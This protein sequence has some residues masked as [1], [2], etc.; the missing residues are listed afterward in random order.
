VSEAGRLFAVFVLVTAVGLATASARVLADGEGNNLPAKFTITTDV[1]V[2]AERIEPLGV[3]RDGDPGGCQFGEN[4]F[5]RNPGNEPFHWRLMARVIKINDDGSVVID[6]PMSE[7]NGALKSGF[8]SGAD[9]RIYRLVDK[10]DGKLPKKPHRSSKDARRPFF[11]DCFYMDPADADHV[12]FVGRTRVIPKGAKGYPMGGWIAET[13][14]KKES[15]DKKTGRKTLL[16]EQDWDRS[17]VCFTDEID[18]HYGDY[19]F[20]D[21]AAFEIDLDTIRLED[22]K[23]GG[24]A[25]ISWHWTPKNCEVSLARH[26]EALPKEMF[27][28]G[29][30]CLKVAANA[31]ACS[32]DQ[33]YMIGG[34][35]YYGD[36]EEGKKYRMEVWL[37]QEGLQGTVNFMFTSLYKDKGE[38]KVTDR[39]QKFV[40]DFV[41]KKSGRLFGVQFTFNGPG[42]LWL[43]NCRIF[44][45]EQDEDLD[46]PHVPGDFTL[47][48]LLDSQPQSGRKGAIRLW[49]GLN[50]NTME[51]LCSLYGGTSA[52]INWSRVLVRERPTL[53]K[54]LMYAESTGDSPETRMVPWQIIQVTFTE[55]EYRNLIEYLGAPYDPEQDTSETKPYAYKR[56]VQRG[57]GAPWTDTFREIIFEFG[58]ENWHNRYPLFPFWIGFG[59]LS[60][61]HQGGKEFGIFTRY[62]TEEM[63][64]SPYWKSQN[65]DEKIKFCLGG[66]YSAK[67]DEKTDRVTGYGQE[68]TQA[69]GLN[70]YEGHANY[71]GPLWELGQNLQQ[72]LCDESF[73]NAL[74]SYTAGSRAKHEKTGAALRKLQEQGFTKH[75]NVAYEG[76]PSGFS[77]TGKGLTKDDLKTIQLIGKSKAIGVSSLHTWL[78]AC[79]LG[80]TH[81][82]YYFYGQ[83]GGWNSH[84]QI[85]QGFLPSPAFIAL[86]MRNRNLRGDMI[87]TKTDSAP[88]ITMGTL[89][90]MTKAAAAKNKGGKG[91]AK[92]S[93]KREVQL[94][95]CFAFRDGDRYSVAVLSLKLD[96]KHSGQ[97]FGDGY[98]R[99]TLNLPFQRAG[100]ITLQKLIGDPRDS[101]MTEEKI[102][103]VEQAVSA[104]AVNGGVFTINQTTGGGAGGIPPG[105]AF[106]YVFEG[107]K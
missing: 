77:I 93:K 83:G 86:E 6:S 48:E 95:E 89:G 68:A 21:T 51:R 34:G 97:D 65:L 19:L 15:I 74:L 46:K 47:Q 81:Q 4:T 96:G 33:K 98:S 8:Y 91:K 59:E 49:T 23:T 25:K 37:R 69:N 66:N 62:Y 1:L 45:Y 54:A 17:R 73:Q 38:F 67:V 43:D 24:R 79:R 28:P 80:F 41:G 85:K 29:T 82:C 2:P 9:V 88:T 72:A 52:G 12:Q 57:H 44:K 32:I 84:S 35:T 18:F 7:W 71:V 26:T 90:S 40:L 60:A 42:A 13:K 64:K 5:I 53:A 16:L 3:N 106:M 50:Q 10:S 27:D 76:G 36:F 30:G 22:K 14:V 101:N 78:D 70:T 20:F 107:V 56:Y 102:K 61:I 99:V 63:M 11:K 58:N 92:P 100:K 94:V 31:G 87:A 55:E 39:W 75:S 105:T 103:M 104:S